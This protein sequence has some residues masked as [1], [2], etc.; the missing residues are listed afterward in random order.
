MQAS[1][2]Q[3]ALLGGLLLGIL[4]AL[5][6]V[7]LG[8]ACCCLWVIVGGV[9]AAYLLQNSQPAPITAGDGAVVGFL[10]GVVG[11]IVWQVLAVPVTLLMGPL[12]ARMLDR[13][14]STGDIPDNMRSV[15]ESL[16]QNAG[17]SIAR[18]VLGGA[19]TLVISVIFSTVGGL[20]GAALFRKKAPPL[21]PELPPEGGTPL[22]GPSY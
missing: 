7:N 6:V 18:F 17:F 20:V 4:S 2:L 15:F 21:P 3:P 9:T 1:K 22:S 12:Q 16:R 8:N 13:L 19:F 14:L 10:A 5:P 11:T